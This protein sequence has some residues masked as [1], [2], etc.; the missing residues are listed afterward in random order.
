MARRSIES[1]LNQINSTQMARQVGG[2]FFPLSADDIC[3]DRRY[4]YGTGS[5]GT[6]PSASLLI[7]HP[8]DSDASNENNAELC[9]SALPRCGRTEIKL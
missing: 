4:K 1:T 2:L 3:S 6:L 8:P 7:P 5:P 9:E